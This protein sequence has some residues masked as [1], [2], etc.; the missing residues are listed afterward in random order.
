MCILWFCLLV[1]RCRWG[2]GDLG[3]GLKS[4]G[5]QWHHM[6]AGYQDRE[7]AGSMQELRA[8]LFCK[9]TKGKLEQRQFLSFHFSILALFSSIPIRYT[10]ICVCLLLC[11]C[12]STIPRSSVEEVSYKLPLSNRWS[13]TK[14]SS[15][16]RAC[17]CQSLSVLPSTSEASGSDFNGAN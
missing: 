13:Q 9:V 12:R 16:S 14:L 10:C 1:T 4:C 15:V 2:E 17:P 5:C 11:C 3:T 8:D 7:G 6:V